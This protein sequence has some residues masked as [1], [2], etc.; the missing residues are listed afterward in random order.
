VIRKKGNEMKFSKLLS[1]SILLLLIFSILYSQQEKE[2]ILEKP[3]IKEK[4]L[5]KILNE[6]KSTREF[7]EK[8]ISDQMLSNLLWAAFGINRPESG[9]RTAP[10]VL[11]LQEIEIYVATTSGL[12]LY[13][14]KY[15][16][17]EL[18]HNIDIREFTGNP[19]TD[20]PK[21]AP[22]NLIFVADLSKYVM[23]GDDE[24]LKKIMVF[25]DV[26]Y[27]SQNV[28]LFC[29]SENLATVVLGAIDTKTLKEK[30]KL[31]EEQLI[32]LTQP[33]G[34]FK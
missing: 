31:R 1:I 24:T 20:F 22:I 4:P 34:H 7:I 30:M 2:I 21:T 23:F 14:P 3:Q 32:L 9:M 19:G 29:A 13:A 28:Y 27:I 8:E 26:G 5:L 25:S 10:S 16:K 12:F 33:V 15:H 6:R 17:L 18:I 11:N